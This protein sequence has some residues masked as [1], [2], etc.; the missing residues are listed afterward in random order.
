MSV[1]ISELIH[2]IKRCPSDFL[3]APM[4]KNQGEVYSEA[5]VNDAFR[6]VSADFASPCP[7]KIQAEKRTPAEL[8]LMQICCWVV[9]HPV[10]A[11]VPSDWFRDFF[12]EG[13]KEVAGLVK[14][15]QWIQDEE[16]AEELA[17]MLLQAC[18]IVPAGESVQEA[19]DRFASV[20]SVNR[21]K[22]IEESR[23]AAQRARE[24]RR[25]MAEKKAR[26]AANVYA[27]E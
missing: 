2:H 20:N 5:L 24:I 6:L 27:R 3:K 15:E 22:V 10:F 23:A 18:K 14:T 13:L 11:T 7:V 4:F 12:A 19:E 16:R 9:S 1:V 17:R 21:M 8:S 26:E 25:K